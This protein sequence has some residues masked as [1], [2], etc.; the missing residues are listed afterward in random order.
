MDD[1]FWKRK[2]SAFLHDA[3][4]KCFDIAGHEA[5]ADARIPDHTIWNHISMSSALAPCIQGDD[6]RPEMLLFQLGPVQDFIAAAR[7]TRDLWSGSYLLSWLMAHAIKAVTDQVGPD[8]VIFPSL[9]GNGIFDALHRESY[10]STKWASGSKGETETTWE[11]LLKDKGGENE[12]ADWLLTPTLPN[13]FFAIVPEGQGAELAESAVA[14]LKKELDC[15]GAA[16]WE[17]LA[18]N[19]AKEEWKDRWKTQIDAFPQTAWAT[20]S[21]LD[22]E[23]CLT[24]AQKLPDK[25]V[26]KRLEN[27]INFAESLPDKDT[28]YFYGDGKLTNAG[29]LWSAHY[30]LLDAKLAARRNTRDF[31]QWDPVTKTAAVKDSLTGREECIGDKDFWGSLAE[32]NERIF[33]A[34]SHRYGAMSLIKRL[35]C[36]AK[37]INYLPKKLELEPEL[38]EKALFKIA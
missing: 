29:I 31:K 27:F 33:K 12:M 20:Q 25:D 4:D 16:V 37:E 18:Q 13:R 28:R 17:W 7:S 21:W 30:A 9:R 24:E 34:S 19:D 22:R 15:I 2:L 3:P 32:H 10:Y 35:W 14:A 1:K 26:A 38:V 11:R 36:R 8:A 5:T 23:A 6:V